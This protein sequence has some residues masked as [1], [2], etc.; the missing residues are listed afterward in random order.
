MIKDVL[1]ICN[2]SDVAQQIE[3]PIPKDINVRVADDIPSAF[4]FTARQFDLIFLDVNLMP[5]NIT[6]DVDRVFRYFSNYNPMVQF[7]ILASRELVRQAVEAVKGCSGSYL[8]YPFDRTEILLVLKTVQESISKSLELDY[9][10]NRFWKPDWL[11]IIQTDNPIMRRIFENIN[12][13]APTIATVLLLGET[14]TGKG[15]MARLIHQ[16][17]HR[18]DGPFVSVHCGAIPDTLLESE[19]FGHEKGAFTGAVQRK[20]GKF[21]LAQEGTIF[22]DEIGT[23]S[24]TAQIKLLQVLQDGSFNRVGST[25]PL[26]TNARIIAAT[27]A[28]LEEMTGSNKF[29][30][31]LFYRL[32]VFP[33]EIPALKDRIED[34]P[35]LTRLF[36]AKLNTKYQKE[37]KGLSPGMHD[38]L[39]SYTW[40][41]NLR[42]L[43]N[44][45]ER[46]LILESGDI[47]KPERFPT[48]LINCLN[49]D[50][51][52]TAIK[53]MPL[54]E[55]R[56]V[57]I[58]EFEKNYL[59]KLLPKHN[60]KVNFS[61][62]AA[63]ISPR[64]L[65][66]LVHKYD[67]DIKAYRH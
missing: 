23:I 27:N 64:Q 9:L 35:H 40:P 8:M 4:V 24:S 5:D 33:I 60:G 1:I 3:S 11:G 39:Q 21:E 65:S 2:N 52:A 53:E 20:F 46:A 38:C 18:C 30:K 15:L 12:S 54:A 50:T 14:G 32:N 62:R 49:T 22:L 10:R 58:E 25:E 67:L 26:H 37:V 41:G 57:V 59:E 16:H 51:A 13:V 47:L 48:S 42:E 44:I 36:L 66:R 6:E 63:G 34:L 19:L 29:R 43:E 45:L 61:A 56:K 7:V 17:S 28:D 31:D 55:S